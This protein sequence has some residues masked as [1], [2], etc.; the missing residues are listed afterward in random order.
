M[1]LYTDIIGMGNTNTVIQVSGK[2]SCDGV[3]K[4]SGLIEY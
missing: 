2:L 3:Y 4:D 1:M